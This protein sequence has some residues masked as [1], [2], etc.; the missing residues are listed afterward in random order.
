MIIIKFLKIKGQFFLFNP[1]H[2]NLNMVSGS[3]TLSP[4]IIFP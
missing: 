1:V 4:L 2:K 3:Q